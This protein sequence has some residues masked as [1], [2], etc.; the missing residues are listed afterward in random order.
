MSN[1]LIVFIRNPVKGK[2]KTRLGRAI[3]DDAAL[4]VYLQLCLLTRNAICTFS[5]KKYLFYSDEIIW[6]DEWDSR[7]F[8]KQRQVGNDLG[9]RISNAFEMAFL[10]HRRILLIGS[11]CPYL[12]PYHLN[13]ALDY[14]N[15]ADCVI[16][17]AKDGGYYLIG[18][19][20]RIPGLFLNK[21]WS[22]SLVFNETCDTLKN[23][24]HSYA[25]LETLEDI[26]NPEDWEHYL[27]DHLKSK[28]NF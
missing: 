27:N 12:K 22:T 16:G 2:V 26:D 10:V 24:N 13:Q 4:Q 5:G 9:E 28:K 1:A 21:S 6:N 19:N 25:L 20:Q 3:G 17:P 15:D 11:D 14:L 8:D 23:D 18:L 7:E